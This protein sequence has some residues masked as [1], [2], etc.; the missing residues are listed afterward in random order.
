MSGQKAAYLRA[1][2]SGWRLWVSLPGVAPAR[3][4]AHTFPPGPG[5][6]VAER[7]AALAELGY[8]PERVGPW[9][10]VEV[11]PANDAA[12]V[13]TIA[14]RSAPL[15]GGPR[16]GV[17]GGASRKSVPERRQ[18]TARNVASARPARAVAAAPPEKPRRALA[19]PGTSR[20]AVLPPAEPDVSA[21]PE[22]R[23]RALALPPVEPSRPLLEL[24]TA[25]PE[26][27]ADR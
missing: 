10:W 8:A 2:K 14:V 16:T 18:A 15:P 6:S 12:V 26:R 25:R 24:T 5:P 21:L 17:T 7:T 9:A 27:V 4:P 19:R 23:P 1:E 3:H 11:S 22:G 13:G 20:P